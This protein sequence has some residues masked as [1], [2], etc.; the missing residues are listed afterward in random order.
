MGHLFHAIERN[1]T[2]LLNFINWSIISIWENLSLALAE[3]VRPHTWF[4]TVLSPFVYPVN[5]YLDIPRFLNMKQRLAESNAL[6]NPESPIFYA[7]YIF[8]AP[9]VHFIII[10]LA[11]HD[12]LYFS[13]KANALS[14]RIIEC[15][16]LYTNVEIAELI[17]CFLT[18]SCYALSSSPSMLALQHI[19]SIVQTI[20]VLFYSYNPQQFST[21]FQ[22]FLTQLK[23]TK[24]NND[25]NTEV[26]KFINQFAINCK[27]DERGFLDKCEFEKT[28]FSEKLELPILSPK[29]FTEDKNLEESIL[30]ASVVILPLYANRIEYFANDC[31]RLENNHSGDHKRVLSHNAINFTAK[32]MPN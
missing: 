9:S 16:S 11:S 5:T 24:F 32:N 4:W 30:Q 2:D 22:S 17:E 29:S 19:A 21:L 27:K 28:G 7:R 18:G 20:G 23:N 3:K 25:A 26:L 8:N 1:N 6:S 14:E 31:N 12:D 15:M 10:T 13:E